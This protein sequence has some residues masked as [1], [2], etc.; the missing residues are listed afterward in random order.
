MHAYVCYACPILCMKTAVQLK[1]LT[2][3]SSLPASATTSPSKLQESFTAGDT[4]GEEPEDDGAPQVF[5]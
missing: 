3:S 2:N 1:E 4:E 5:F